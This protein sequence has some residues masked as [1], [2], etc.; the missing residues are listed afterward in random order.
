M[1]SL[2]WLGNLYGSQESVKAHYSK[3]NLD[4]DIRGN[5]A[6]AFIAKGNI[7]AGVEAKT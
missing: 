2:I 6:R 5:H 3:W 1:A 4:E 7:I